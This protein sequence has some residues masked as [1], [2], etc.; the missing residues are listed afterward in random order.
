MSLAVLIP[1]AAM[2]ALPADKEGEI[3]SSAAKLLTE[4]LARCDVL[5]MG[6]G[7]SAARQTSD[8]VATM[9]RKVEEKTI[10][11]LDAAALTCASDL[12]ADIRSLEGRVI[13]TPHH[14]E[15]SYLTGATSEAIAA[16]PAKAAREVATAYGAVVLLKGADTFL[17]APYGET[18]LFDG[19]CPG[20]ATGGSGD[21]LAGLIGGLAARGAKPVEAC[22]WGALIH[23]RAGMALSEQ[24]GTVGFLAREL[25][26][27]L[28]H[29]IDD[30]YEDQ[31][32]GRFSVQK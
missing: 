16:D 3:A 18:L 1:E 6:P 25:L 23:G 29:L 15:M 24:I 7:M 26:P 27:L 12:E 2:I 11:I 21:V 4:R 22:A 9:L 30:A 8:L 20:L 10:V 14:G 32:M 13:I 19:G 5:I 28:P 17:A 31:R